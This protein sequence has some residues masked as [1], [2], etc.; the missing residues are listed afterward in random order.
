M[1]HIYYGDD[2]TK[3]DAAAKKVLGQN[4]EIIDAEN[5]ELSDLPTIFMG[6]SLFEADSRKILLKGLADKKELFDELEKY[7][8]TPHEIV[9]LETKIDGKWGS[10]KN[11]KKAQNID[12]V[13]NKI[14]EDPKERWLAFN[15]YDLALKNPDAAIK[16]LRENEETEDP[17]AMIGAWATSAIKNLK[18]A[19]N[20]KHNRTIVKKLAEID[21]LLKTTK[22]SESPW[23]ILESF[24]LRL[25]TF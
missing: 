4:Y 2:R 12:I 24:L 19:P 6:A 7:L 21:N 23:P 8:N 22:F 11:L 3:S 16:I 9:I 25:K 18:S 20:S 14:P 10:F 1:L 5:L 15:I 17:Y 13:E